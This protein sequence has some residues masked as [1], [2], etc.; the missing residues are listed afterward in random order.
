M[1]DDQYILDIQDE[2][3]IVWDD[4]GPTLRVTGQREDLFRLFCYKE[5]PANLFAGTSLNV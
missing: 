1:V 5:M 2:L 3:G 4:M